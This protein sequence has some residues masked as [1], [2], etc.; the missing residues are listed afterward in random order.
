MVHPGFPIEEGSSSNRRL[1]AL[2]KVTVHSSVSRSET[3]APASESLV[4]LLAAPEPLRV[5]DVARFESFP[6]HIRAAHDRS[7][8]HR[9]EVLAS[10]V[11]ACFS[12]LE[13]FSP[14]AISEW[15]DTP[16]DEGEGETALCPMCGIDAVLGSSS[17]LPIDGDFLKEMQLYWFS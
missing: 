14:E 9:A 7:S 8:N 3:E 1:N 11:C 4:P 5:G 2:G 17:G 12:C 16:T 13:T 6:P 10:D 15:V